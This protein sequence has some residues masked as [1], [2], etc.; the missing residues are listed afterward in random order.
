MCVYVC[1]CV[2]AS[3]CVVCLY[4]CIAYSGKFHEVKMS[5]FFMFFHIVFVSTP[6][7]NAHPIDI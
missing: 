7:C 5:C 1:V 3:S 4:V 2:S 6:V